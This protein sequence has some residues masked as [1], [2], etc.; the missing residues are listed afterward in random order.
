M[1]ARPPQDRPLR[2]PRTCN[3]CRALITVDSL[4]IHCDL[5]YPLKVSLTDTNSPLLIADIR[6]TATCPKPLT[7]EQFFRSPDYAG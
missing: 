7:W 6:P 2:K 1:S 4:N 5:G 3:K